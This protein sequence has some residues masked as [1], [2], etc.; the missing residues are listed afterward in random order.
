RQKILFMRSKPYVKVL[1]YRLRNIFDRNLLQ[2]MRDGL[3]KRDLVKNCVGQLMK[4]RL[5]LLPWRK[6]CID[7]YLFFSFVAKAQ[8]SVVVRK[9]LNCPDRVSRA[10]NKQAFFLHFTASMQRILSQHKGPLFNATA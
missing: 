9:V 7:A 1:I 8:N 10:K 6:A 5:N 2:P 4:Q 3:I